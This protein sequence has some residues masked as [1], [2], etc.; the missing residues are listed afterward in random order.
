MMVSMVVVLLIYR[1]IKLEWVRVTLLSAAVILLVFWT[2]ERNS[3][4]A[5]DLILWRDCVEKSP[6]KARPHNNLGIALASRG[7]FKEASGHYSEALRIRP[8]FPKAHNNLGVALASQGKLGEAVVHYS[9]ALRIEP[10]YA[11]AH[12]N[13]GAA[14]A[15]Q[16]KLGEAMGH[17]SEALR[18][19]P[20]YADTRW[21]L[22]HF[23]QRIGKSPG[24]A[25]T[26][27]RP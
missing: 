22:E 14:L 4:W 9:Q 1:T 7:R 10:D 2:Y 27:V 21:N 24:A 11:E 3:V 12:N 13:L 18:I 25:N 19:K 8:D 26:A 15:R 6:K 5:D 17:F 20:D 16:G 23:L